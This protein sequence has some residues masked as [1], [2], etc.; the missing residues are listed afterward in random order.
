MRRA[1]A[2]EREK[3]AKKRKLLHEL[4]ETCLP[5][6]TPKDPGFHQL[7]SLKRKGR[8]LEE[9][10][11]IWIQGLR[12]DNL[13]MTHQHCVLAGRQSRFSS[14]H[15]VAECSTG[16]LP[17]IL[18]K[19]KAAL[20]NLNT[21]ADLKVPCL[22]SLEVGDITQV[23][24]THNEVEFEWLRQF[25]FQGKRYRRCTDWWDKPMANLEDLWRQMELMTS[26]L[27]REL[28]KEEQ[29]E[30]QRNE[31]ISSLLPLLVERQARR[32]EWL[33]R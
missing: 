27:L 15:R 32:Q 25:W 26:L 2:E 21:D 11:L 33:V 20:E 30:E 23:E 5:Y 29:M 7:V 9:F 31:K 14:T 24:K 22:K 6:L 12:P 17:Y 16:T 10:N 28:R 1:R 18:D 3:E 8:D 19:C 13:N 4:G